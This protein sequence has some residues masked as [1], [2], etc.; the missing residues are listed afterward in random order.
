MG[1]EHFKHDQFL[2]IAAKHG[3][4][5]I[6]F[7]SDAPW[8]NAQT[9]INHIKSLPLPRE[10]IDAILSGNARRILSLS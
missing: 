5:K 7:G 1:F 10:S 6:L 3:T 8:S 9:E 4:D 2:R